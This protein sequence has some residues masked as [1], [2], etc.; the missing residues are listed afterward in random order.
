MI[1]EDMEDL[2]RQLMELS[3][4]KDEGWKKLNEQLTEIEHLR[5]VINEQERMLE[6]R[7]VGLISQEE[8][9]KELRNDK[10][11]SLKIVAQLK[12]ERD[13]AATTA[14]RLSAQVNA[15]EDENKRLGRLSG[16]FGVD[17]GHRGRRAFSQNG[18]GVAQASAAMR[19][20][21]HRGK[22]RAHRDRA[23][24]A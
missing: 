15:L 5:E 10:E 16:V 2:N 8:V 20:H 7:R 3:R 13:E 17:L 9:I 11:K 6:E 21:H 19:P 24:L 22:S 14:S 1:R 4:T 23:A 18:V 12:A